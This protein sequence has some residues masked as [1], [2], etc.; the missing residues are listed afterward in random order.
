MTSRVAIAG[1]IAVVL[2]VVAVVLNRGSKDGGRVAAGASSDRSSTTLAGGRAGGSDSGGQVDAGGGGKGAQPATAR[3]GVVSGT[4]TPLPLKLSTAN[5]SGLRDGDEVH[6]HVDADK[7]SAIYAVE[8]WQC[9]GGVTYL[10]DT[11]VRPTWT[12]KC[13]SKNLSANSERSKV[14]PGAPPFSLVDGTFRVGTGVDTYETRDG[15]TTTVA[16]DAAH[17]CLLVLKLQIPNGYGFKSIPLTF[18]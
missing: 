12:G 17:P 18:K 14:I 11:D 10:Y 7:G 5:T 6:V 4:D 1:A 3:D 2:V 16:C 9:K 8:A 13:L 15:R